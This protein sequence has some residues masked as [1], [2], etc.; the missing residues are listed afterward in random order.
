MQD[1][2]GGDAAAALVV[3]GTTFLAAEAGSDHPELFF[4]DG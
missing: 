4:Y 1:R 3:L 2:L